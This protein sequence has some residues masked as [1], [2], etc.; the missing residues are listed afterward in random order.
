MDKWKGKIKNIDEWNGMAKFVY[1][2]DKPEQEPFT[3]LDAIMARVFDVGSVHVQAAFARN[4]RAWVSSQTRP[5]STCEEL[6]E[7][8]EK[9]EIGG[10]DASLFRRLWNA[11]RVVRAA[12]GVED[13]AVIIRRKALLELATVYEEVIERIRAAKKLGESGLRHGQVAPAKARKIL[14]TTLYPGVKDQ[15]RMK[16]LFEYNMKCASSYLFLHKHYGHDGI[17]AMIPARINE[18]ETGISTR[19]PATREFLDFLRPGLHG[20]FPRFCSGVI[21]ALFR[22]RPLSEETLKRLD[23]GV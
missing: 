1:I 19:F 16:G 6:P 12:K 15:K 22:G 18:K 17:L 3:E 2:G 11:D 23:D 20:E 5:V 14:Y 4:V 21:D 10:I 9:H 13:I 7:H 8:L